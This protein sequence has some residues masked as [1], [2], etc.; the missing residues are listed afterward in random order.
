MDALQFAN[1]FSTAKPGSKIVYF[2]G[3]L[4]AH[5]QKPEVA[6]LAWRYGC[7]K[8]V[9][10]KKTEGFNE[11]AQYGAGL[12]YLVQE[13]IEANLYKYYIIKKKRNLW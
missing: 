10:L 6:D 7:P 9:A 5:E 11:R 13:R 3:H 8:N 4:M 12:G 2:V 1:T